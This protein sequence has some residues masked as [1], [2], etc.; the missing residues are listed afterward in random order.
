[1]PIAREETL[2]KESR[3]NDRRFWRAV[4]LVMA[5]TTLTAGMAEA[6]PA[7]RRW[8]PAVRKARWRPARGAWRPRRA[9]PPRAVAM[10]RPRAQVA[11]D[12]LAVAL[13]RGPMALLTLPRRKSPIVAGATAMA[14]VAAPAHTHFSIPVTRVPRQA[15]RDAGCAGVGALAMLA[16]AGLACGV[17]RRRGSRRQLERLESL[18]LGPGQA[19]HVV[20]YG[21]RQLLLTGSMHGL[22]VLAEDAAQPEPEMA[23][24]VLPGARESAQERQED[25]LQVLTAPRPEV[26]GL[27]HALQQ[28]G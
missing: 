1:M 6:A 19:L 24:Q 25:L 13:A 11:P 16:L 26:R 20:R 23:L 27:G 9:W 2:R 5:L 10:P 22:Q 14:T 3:M 4:T 7:A 28:T 8:R 15:L 21:E 18:R 17:Q 12:A